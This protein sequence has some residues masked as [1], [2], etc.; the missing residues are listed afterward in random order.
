LSF[1]A[2]FHASVFDGLPLVIR[3]IVELPLDTMFFLQRSSHK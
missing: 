1:W 3:T 2:T